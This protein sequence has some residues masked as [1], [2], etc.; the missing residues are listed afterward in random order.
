MNKKI[1]IALLALLIPV[2]ASATTLRVVQTPTLHLYA[3]ESAAATTMRVTPY[4]KDLDGTKLTI[5]D[6]G[7]LPTVTVD[8]K[9]TG[10]EEIEGFTAIVDNGD[11][12]ATLTGL[13]RDLTSK[14]PY[15]TAGTGRAHGAGATVVFGNNPQIYG[16]LWAPENQATST[17]ILYF[18]STLM[19]R[20][21]VDPGAAA[22]TLAPNTV[23]VNM[24]QLTRTSIAGATNATRSAQGL[25]QVANRGD[26]SISTALGST[27]AFMCL[28]TDIATSS[29]SISMATSSV[30]MTGSDG[31]IS[32]TFMS[33]S[34]VYTLGGIVSNASS[35]FLGTTTIAASNASTSALVLNGL[36]YQ[37]SASRGASSTVLT[38]NGYGHLAWQKPDWSILVSTTTTTSQ[39]TTS[40]T[41]IPA[42]TDLRLVIDT[43][44]IGGNDSF[45]IQFNGDTGQNYAY[46]G[47][48]SGAA[49]FSGTGASIT[50]VPLGSL[51]GTPFVTHF[52]ISNTATRIKSL[53]GIIVQP[54]SGGASFST[55]G[56]S[57]NNTSNSISSIQMGC[58]PT[59]CPSGMRITVY[60]SNF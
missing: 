50:V 58:A 47:L 19:P 53:S 8:P 60:G 35:T 38:E 36:P 37:V 55:V 34:S 12:T 13:T 11:N 2:I 43:G 44:A 6:L 17:A 51:A 5:A 27:G 39:A 48:S 56:G 3:G 20:F 33:T 23:F 46:G 31:R 29:P 28:T 9:I 24:A 10:I 57:W 16:R 21:D 25:V 52:D 41:G 49:T 22:Y 7:T 4:P 18:T 32:P 30:V 1:G 40:V 59:A 45:N 42:A 26:A 15:T 54:T 14:Y